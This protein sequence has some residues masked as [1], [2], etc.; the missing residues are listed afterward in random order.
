[1]CL[2]LQDS[3]TSALQHRLEHLL[4]VAYRMQDN[5]ERLC[6]RHADHVALGTALSA[7]TGIEDELVRQWGYDDDSSDQDSFVSA[8]D[9]SLCLA[10]SS[11]VK[12]VVWN[13]L[14]KT[15]FPLQTLEK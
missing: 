8:T 6:E 12:V 10:S 13:F 14:K 11:D 7:F 15:D 2:L 3:D 4:D 9:V 5:Y 1:M